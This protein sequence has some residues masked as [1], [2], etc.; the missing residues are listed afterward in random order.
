MS[1]NNFTL[2][3]RKE[4]LSCYISNN[5]C[6]LPHLHYHVEIMHV[7]SGKIEVTFNQQTRILTAGDTA[8][9]F[10]NQIHTGTTLGNSRVLFFIFSAE[11]LPDLKQG[12][13][14]HILTNPFIP[15]EELTPLSIHT[16]EACIQM[17][18]K[19]PRDCSSP[20][21]QNTY[22]GILMI[23]VTDLL[24]LSGLIKRPCNPQINMYQS[25]LDYI[26]DNL[27]QKLTLEKV[28]KDLGINKYYISRLFSNEF[29]IRFNDYISKKRLLLAEA[30]IRESDKKMIEIMYETGFTS[31]RTFYRSFK[32]YFGITPQQ[33]KNKIDQ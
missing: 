19:H 33:L 31:E 11:I 26:E 18:E 17:Q 13:T 4:N 32:E 21:L 2:E 25:V 12:L 24:S 20:F 10:P 7:I 15:Q 9:A 8:I 6:F 28:A 1:M 22:K 14:T 23:L 27:T 16:L 5:I 3:S 30:L 29:K